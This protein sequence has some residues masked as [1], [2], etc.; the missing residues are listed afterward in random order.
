M[1]NKWKEIDAER[2]RILKQTDRLRKVGELVII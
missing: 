2:L 1:L